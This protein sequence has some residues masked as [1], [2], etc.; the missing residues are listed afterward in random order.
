MSSLTPRSKSGSDFLTRCR[1]SASPP[2]SQCAMP[3]Q[4]PGPVTN[5]RDAFCTRTCFTSHY[6]SSA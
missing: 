2:L 3:V 6:R 1:A 5:E 4:A